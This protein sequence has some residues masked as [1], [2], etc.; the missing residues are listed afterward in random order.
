[1][2]LPIFVGILGVT[3]C[4][5]PDI[6]RGAYG[7]A[8]GSESG[9]L[10]STSGE[11]DA[12]LERPEL[13]GESSDDGGPAFLVQPDGAGSGIWE[14]E[15]REQT[16][17]PH[18]KCNLWASDGGAAWNATKC[19]PVVDDPDQDGESC[20]AI[21]S[22]VSGFD[23]CDRGMICWDV[24]PVSLVGMCVPYCIGTSQNPTCRDPDKTCGGNKDFLFCMHE[25][26]PLQPATGAAGKTD[27]GLAICPLGC[28]CYPDFGGFL[29]SPDVSGDAGEPGDACEF[30][31]SCDPGSIC[32]SPE[33]APVCD[34]HAS[35]CC[36][37]VCDLSDPDGDAGCAALDPDTACLGWYEEDQAPPGYENLGLCALLA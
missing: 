28:G 27:E 1:M 34:P 10:S 32:G 33:A 3:A 11:P 9:V 19:V 4:A 2:R 6:P 25:C 20:T 7:Q 30:R 18:E 15:L 36:L 12:P 23:S 35:G 17:R 24:D 8:D 31:N 14:C 16:C 26:D 13:S 37:P 5:G 29:C 22:G 21:G